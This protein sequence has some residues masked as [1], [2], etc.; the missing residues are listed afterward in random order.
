[1]LNDASIQAVKEAQ[2]NPHFIKPLYD[3]YCFTQ[4]PGLVT[5][6]FRSER[7]AEGDLLLGPL[8]GKYDKVVL[9][10]ID[11]F[12]WRFFEKYA[13]G[14]PFLRRILHEGYVSKITSQFP[15]TTAAHVTDIHTGLPVDQSG[16]FEW[17]YYEPVLD[18]MIA[19]LLFSYAGDTQP[20]TLLADGVKPQDIFPYPVKTLYNRL[21]DIGVRS[22]VYQDASFTPSPHGALAFNG[23]EVVPFPDLRQGLLHLAERLPRDASPA[24]YFLYFDGIDHAGHKYGPDSPQFGASVHDTMTM[25]E[26]LFQPALDRANGK[27][28]FLMTADHGQ[29]HTDP[30]TTIFLNRELPAMARYT[31]TNRKGTFLAPGGSARDLFLYIKEEYLDEAHAAITDLVRGRA[32]VYRTSD[33]IAQHFFGSGTPAQRFLDRV[34]N[35]VV[36]PYEGESVFWYEQGRFDNPFRGHHGGLTR[37]EMETILLARSS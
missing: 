35:L 12:G 5:S 25:L 9:F 29:T 26:S 11:A 7:S 24:Y 27:T 34:G 18:A 20:G 1:M 13:D 4:L 10:F 30:A 8:S 21:G 14:Y 32:E 22:V 37:H 3:S 16:V 6:S 2:W 28:L 31:R 36:L 33:L 23:A 15:S 19:P 17:Y